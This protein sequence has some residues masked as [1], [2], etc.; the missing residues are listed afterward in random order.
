MLYI[1]FGDAIFGAGGCD[2]HLAEVHKL[3]AI[4]VSFRRAPLA[5]LERRITDEK[6]AQAWLHERGLPL[7]VAWG[8]VNEVRNGVGADVHGAPAPALP[9][10]KPMW[11]RLN[12]LSHE[13]GY[14]SKE[15]ILLGE[16]A[17]LVKARGL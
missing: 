9:E 14:D 17:Q 12:A 5:E 13:Y 4:A 8:L 16:A 15:A 7:M 1:R 6:G 11:Q 10:G 2:V 3:Q